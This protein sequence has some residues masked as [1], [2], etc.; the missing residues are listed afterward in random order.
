MVVAFDDLE[1]TLPYCDH[2]NLFMGVLQTASTVANPV[3]SRAIAPSPVRSVVVAVATVVD[4]AAT[5]VVVSV[6]RA[7]TLV[8]V[9]W[10]LD[11]DLYCMY[12]NI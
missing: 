5:V 1:L 11:L 12:E 7:E 2:Y 3:T 9:F 6:V 4:V 8:I 10:N